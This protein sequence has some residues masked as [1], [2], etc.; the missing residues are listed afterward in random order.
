[1]FFLG[2]ALVACL[3]IDKVENKRLIKELHPIG[4]CCPWLS[5]VHLVNTHH[6]CL[7]LTLLFEAK[8]G[9]PY[10]QS[11]DTEYVL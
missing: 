6:Y 5:G 9:F 3:Q 7:L 8:V 2:A 11:L 4:P 10:N 1:M